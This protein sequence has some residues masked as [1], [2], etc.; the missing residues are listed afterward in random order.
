MRIVAVA[1]AIGGAGLLAG[2]GSEPPSPGDLVVTSEPSGAAI[3][4]DGAT[5]G[6]ATPHTFADLEGGVTHTVSVA[7][8]GWSV[9]P[10][11]RTVEIPF[12]SKATAAFT[13][14]QGL[15]S[16]VVNSDPAGAAILID[17]Q[18]TGE[19][20]PHTFEDQTPGDYAVAV[21][22]PY[23]TSEEGELLA[24]VEAGGATTL[25]FELGIARVVLLEGFSNVYCVGC[26]VMN[27]NIDFLLHQPGYG[28]RRLLFLKW[29]AIL[30]PLD[31]FY[32]VTQTITNARVSWYFGSSQ[33]SLP[34]LNGDGSLLGNHGTPVGSA[35]MTAF[36]DGQ[37][38]F[39]EVIVMVETDEDLND[40]SDLTHDATV[41]LLAPDGLDLG[42]YRLDVV[43]VYESVETENEGYIDGITEFHWVMR[44]HVNLA[45]DLGN[46]DAGV[47]YP[48]TVTLEDPLGGELDGHAVYP[49]NKQIIAWIQ[50]ATTRAVIQAG[51]TATA[52]TDLAAAP[53]NPDAPRVLLSGG[54]R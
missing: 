7:L 5:T 14:S 6:E 42:G 12:G 28:P 48:F 31:P 37:P 23:Y 18:P 41:T 11:S 43:L 51:S 33:I 10:G 9:Q 15:G 30:S 35:G 52:A 22:L 24:T 16:L 44:D 39:A 34:T 8:E 54:S 1:L 17:G 21:D 53:T 40:V 26:P 4:L 38:L 36:V 50:H 45:D 25:D 2:C 29:P 20:T 46:L 13:L 3:T 19:V 47:S 27:S 49:D 32:F